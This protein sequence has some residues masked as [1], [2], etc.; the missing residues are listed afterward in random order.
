MKKD[1]KR[2]PWFLF[3]FWLI[4]KLVMGIVEFTGRILAIVLGFVLMVVGII[5]SAT[6][7]GLIIGLPMILIGVLLVLRGIF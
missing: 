4:W 7:V 2:I 5:I 3:P 1:R 6:I